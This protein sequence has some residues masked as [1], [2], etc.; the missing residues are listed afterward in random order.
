MAE[1]RERA[2]ARIFETNL[3]SIKQPTLKNQFKQEAQSR[4]NE[5]FLSQFQHGMDQ[6][7]SGLS[8]AKAPEIKKEK[9]MS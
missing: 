7:V 5:Q 4:V 8:I 2:R 6:V 9:S 1:M 3:L